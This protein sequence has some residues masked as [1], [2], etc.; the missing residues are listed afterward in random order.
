MVGG[1]TT[2]PLLSRIP[3]RRRR[4][5]LSHLVREIRPREE[6]LDQRLGLV[7]GERLEQDRRRVHL[8]STPAGTGIEEF[9]PRH[10]Q[11]EDRRLSAPVG[12]VV[13]EIEQ[14]LLCPVQ[15]VEDQDQRAAPGERLEEP[16]CSAERVFT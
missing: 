1:T 16:S 15:V 2:S 8:P 13:D 12:Y 10:A 4:D 3:F 14:C 9:G 6:V 7:F 5:P 11:Q